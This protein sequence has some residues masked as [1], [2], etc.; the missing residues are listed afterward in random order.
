MGVKRGGGVRRRSRFGLLSLVAA[1]LLVLAP[2]STASAQT[3][4]WASSWASAQMLVDPKDALPAPTQ[5]DLT[6]RQLVRITAG[7][8]RLRITV[9][10]VFGTAPLTIS[11]VNVA[12]AVSPGSSRVDPST[13]RP[14]T[15]NGVRTAIIPAGAEYV[16]DPIAL[17]APALTTLAISINL[18]EVPT[19]QT[20]H[21]GSRAT[22]YFLGG[23]H[24]SAPE[25]EGAQTVDRWYF[26]SGV[27][28]LPPAPV[29]AI[30]VLGDSITDGH[31]VVSN[32]DTRW[33]DTLAQRLK[34]FAATR[35]LAVLNL[36]IGGNR[37]VDDGL[38]PNAA[39]RFGRDVLDRRSVKY[40][41]I[42]EGV[43]DLGVLTR[44]APASPEQHGTMVKRMV[45]AL[46]QMVSRARERGIKVIGATIL[47]FGASDYYHPGAA[48]EADR[49]MVNAWIR[50]PG[51]V[52]AVID[53]DALMRDPAHP[54]RMRKE[55]DSDG[56]HPNAAGYRL[57]GEAVPLSLFTAR[58]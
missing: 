37:L 33:T 10:N 22:S 30:A 24:L 9:S 17:P 51:N 19:R 7:G 1:T 11:G 45:G 42:L 52:D 23:D 58:R 46:A 54:S 25:L 43:N 26:L 4:R 6:L 18:A 36:G 48:T 40:L 15:F 27:D 29:M 31:G 16:S 8:T 56:L 3:Q 13:D 12:R 5:K 20:G 44:D 49:Q 41:I 14:V 50:R 38:G 39:A 28:V 35:S 2:W 53:F 55:L 32:T 47:P 34:A 21:P 57:M